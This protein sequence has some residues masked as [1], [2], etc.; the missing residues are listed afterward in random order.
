VNLNPI[1]KRIEDAS[2]A[3]RGRDLFINMMP[4][5]KTGILL[6]DYFGGTAIDHYLPGFFKASFMV[7]VRHPSYQSAEQ[8]IKR[9]VA[10]LI[11]E[12]KT[13]VEGVVFHYIRPRGLPFTYA[14]SPGQNHE[15]AVNMDCCFIDAAPWAV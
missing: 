2:V 15:F 4:A 5:D 9:A 3:I 6:R 1:A 13:T 11:V 12:Q 10:A 14:P 8:L 7:I